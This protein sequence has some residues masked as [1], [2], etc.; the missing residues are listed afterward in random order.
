M[1]NQ[2]FASRT[3]TPSQSEIFCSGPA[4]PPKEKYSQ[5]IVLKLVIRHTGD[6]AYDSY[7]ADT[8]STEE[9]LQAKEADQVRE[10]PRDQ[11]QT[12][13]S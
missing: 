5:N 9:R 10:R 13:T 11:C 1:L 12:H 7:I 4:H 6:T 3:S 8:D 2:L